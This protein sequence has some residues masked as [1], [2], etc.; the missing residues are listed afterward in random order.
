M[1]IVL[2][3]YYLI[4]ALITDDKYVM[5]IF[6]TKFIVYERLILK[7]TTQNKQT[8]KQTNKQKPAVE[9]F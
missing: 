2:P 6:S 5:K 7:Q 3:K 9:R 8:K 1:R 4:I